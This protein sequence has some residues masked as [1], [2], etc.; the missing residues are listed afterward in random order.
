MNGFNKKKIY[1]NYVSICDG[2]V[3]ILGLKWNQKT[4]SI[5]LSVAKQLNV[6]LELLNLFADNS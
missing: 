2:N 5:F 4:D 3:I 6:L 1:K